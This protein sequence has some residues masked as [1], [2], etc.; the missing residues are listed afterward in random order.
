MKKLSPEEVARFINCRA[1]YIEGGTFCVVRVRYAEATDWGIRAVLSMDA[2]LV[3][4]YRE[5]PRR[6][7]EGERPFGEQWDVS[8]TWKW[9]YPDETRWDALPYAGFHLLFAED[10]VQRFL[11]RDL[12]WTD[13]YF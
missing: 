5:K 10:V 3:C 2:P 9:F 4:H 8:S 11:D 13:D 1:V 7:T 6:F 12:G